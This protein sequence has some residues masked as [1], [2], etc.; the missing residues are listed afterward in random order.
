M[1][2]MYFLIWCPHLGSWE[3]VFQEELCMISRT[4]RNMIFSM[5]VTFS[6]RISLSSSFSEGME[7]E[8]KFNSVHPVSIS[9]HKGE[10]VCH[11]SQN[12]LQKEEG[13]SP[14]ELRSTLSLDEMALISRA[15][16][17]W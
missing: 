5:R 4:D 3:P 14:Q 7:G 2:F 16:S 10:T 12:R 9:L 1:E 6:Q 13:A 8:S 15:S 17:S 11:S